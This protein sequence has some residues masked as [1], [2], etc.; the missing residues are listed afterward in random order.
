MRILGNGAV[1]VAHTFGSTITQTNLSTLAVGNSGFIHGWTG[2]YTNAM[3][4]LNM[5]ES[6]TG[7]KSVNSSIGSTA[8]NMDA[9]L[10]IWFGSAPAT[11][12]TVV[13]DN[14]MV[15]KAS[16]NLGI[17]IDAPN[18][19]LH[20]HSSSS[21]SAQIRLTDVST[22]TG[23]TDGLLLSID[24]SQQKYL[25]NYEN[26]ALF[27][28]T[29]NATSM[30]INGSGNVGIG[31]TT[32]PSDSHTTYQRGLYTGYSAG[33]VGHATGNSMYHL[34]NVYVKQSTGQWTY[35]NAGYASNLIQNSVGGYSFYGAPTGSA[36]ATVSGLIHVFGLDNIGNSNFG[37]NPTTIGNPKAWATT[38]NGIQLNGLT[39]M[40]GTGSTSSSYVNSNLYYDSGG[41]KFLGD[42][43]PSIMANG[44]G[45]FIF[46]KGVTNNGSGAGAD[47]TGSYSATVKF[48]QT[49][50]VTI[51]DSAAPTA[52]AGTSQLYSTGGELYAQDSS[53]NQTQLSPHNETGEWIFNSK[54]S[55]TGKHININMEKL[56][57]F[58]EE[59]H[60]K[61]FIEEII[62]E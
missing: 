37:I 29:N 2:V 14:K 60:G 34:N 51:Y 41:W 31:T 55:K 16:G 5:Y 56:I 30:Y 13:M 3:F 46:Y 12:G 4:A 57:R 40:A 15:L 26:T 28:G 39:L 11:A 45:A 7:W 62:G 10:D 44:G 59:Y 42:G 54:N 8:I 22:G 18:E 17:G 61:E 50:G 52:T 9:N 1:G 24:G 6:S 53:G 48:D 20:V 33:I 19:P 49:G 27:L 58:L 32:I 23:N 38:Y 35:R 36:G 47:A 21:G 25:W 43:Y